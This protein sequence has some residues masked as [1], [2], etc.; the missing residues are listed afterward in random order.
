MEKEDYKVWCGDSVTQVV[1]E[2][3]TDKVNDAK[4]TKES[5]TA[6]GSWPEEFY[7]ESLVVETRLDVLEGLLSVL[8]G[9]A[10]EE[11]DGE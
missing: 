8:Q 11:V 7:K 5:L 3:L 1:S 10:W 4:A 9:K 2:L 6:T